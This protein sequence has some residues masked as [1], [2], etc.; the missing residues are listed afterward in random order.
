[1]CK[2]GSV[3]SIG[4]IYNFFR[5]RTPFI[6]KSFPP[7]PV[8]RRPL[9]SKTKSEADGSA[10]HCLS[11]FACQESKWIS[12]FLGAPN[13]AAN[14]ISKVLKPSPLARVTPTGR[15]FVSRRPSN[16]ATNYIRNAGSRR[17]TTP[18]RLFGFRQGQL[19]V[20][21][22][23]MRFIIQTPGACLWLASLLH[24]TA[25]SGSQSV[26][27]LPSWVGI[28]QVQFRSFCHSISKIHHFT[29]TI[30]SPAV[31]PAIIRLKE[32]PGGPYSGHFRRQ[33][34]QPARDSILRSARPLNLG[35]V[36]YSSPP[37]DPYTLIDTTRDRSAT[38]GV[39]WNL[40]FAARAL[41]VQ[42]QEGETTGASSPGSLRSTFGRRTGP[43][44]LGKSI[45]ASVV[46]F[47]FARRLY[48]N[49]KKRTERCFGDMRRSL[50]R[51]F[52]LLATF[53][54]SYALL[55]YDCYGTVE[56]GD[57]VTSTA[58]CL[59]NLKPPRGS[60]KKEPQAGCWL[61][62]DGVGKHCLCTTDFCNRLRDRTLAKHD[63]EGGN[64]SEATE[65]DF[66]YTS[67]RTPELGC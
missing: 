40:R 47:C 22:A 41:P 21:E 42:A 37:P 61:E 4:P 39:K 51:T 30:P 56:A 16:V 6:T 7:N 25:V 29:S 18:P 52:G 65:G 24:Y 14:H 44:L 63:V 45:A 50:L 2:I 31:S 43:F 59:L 8:L 20:A 67:L 35:A 64:D 12:D 13:V 15:F 23:R 11:L 55:C 58:F 34:K 26:C 17:G 10:A 9:V 3:P 27:R 1:M 38:R 36:R 32:L 49:K 46:A 48:Q 60:A 33:S 57:N 54:V 28:V 19:V 5:R 62:P 66:V 53:S